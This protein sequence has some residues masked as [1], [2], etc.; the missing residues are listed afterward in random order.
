MQ[1]TSLGVGK[2]NEVLQKENGWITSIH[3]MATKYGQ[4]TKLV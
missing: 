3:A 4:E 1:G 2:K